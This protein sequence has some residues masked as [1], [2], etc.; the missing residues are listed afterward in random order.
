MAEHT[1]YVSMLFSQ[2]ILGRNRDADIEKGLVDTAGEGEGVA[3]FK[4]LSL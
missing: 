1:G 3:G 2:F 4:T